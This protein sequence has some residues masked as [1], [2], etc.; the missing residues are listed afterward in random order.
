MH[1]K[2]PK[3]L[4]CI[5]F[6]RLR[7]K[8]VQAG[9]LFPDERR[10]NVRTPLTQINLCSD[11]SSA[12]VTPIQDSEISP[13]CETTL[14]D[15]CSPE[16]VQ[17]EKKETPGFREDDF[18]LDADVPSDNVPAVEQATAQN[19]TIKQHATPKQ[20]ALFS[21]PVDDCITGLYSFW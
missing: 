3:T 15:L 21:T 2:H 4:L 8:N 5:L 1:P 12:P 16:P 7:G 14:I 10:R 17:E 18:L 20:I 11:E 13:A 19:A 9:S 6:T